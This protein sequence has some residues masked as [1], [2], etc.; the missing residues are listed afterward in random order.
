MIVISQPAPSFSGSI[1]SNA[2]VPEKPPVTC[3]TARSERRWTRASAIRPPTRTKTKTKKPTAKA[4]AS[5]P[6]R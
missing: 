6:A 3:E 5:V 2:A 4:K 1:G